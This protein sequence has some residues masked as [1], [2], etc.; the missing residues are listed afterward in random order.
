MLD[1]R[2]VSLRGFTEGET[3]GR[4]LLVETLR[5]V[6]HSKR[7][8]KSKRKLV[9]LK[10]KAA[11]SAEQLQA[12]RDERAKRR[13]GESKDVVEEEPELPLPELQRDEPY[14]DPLSHLAENAKNMAV[15]EEVA[16]SSEVCSEAG[17]AKSEATSE[18][19]H[20]SEMSVDALADLNWTRLYDHFLE[21][22]LPCNIKGKVTEFVAEGMGLSLR[23]RHNKKSEGLFNLQSLSILKELN[24]YGLPEAR[25][26]MRRRATAAGLPPNAPLTIEFS[27]SAERSTEQDAQNANEIA[28]S[29]ET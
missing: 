12:E 19:S 16:Q 26:A 18:S 2:D 1:K 7:K 4:G 24:S 13:K 10:G 9:N 25:V 27:Q 8:G 21:S 6:T 3:S 14:V 29:N 11:K 22:G 28:S 5:K 15:L 20:E 23:N 17:E